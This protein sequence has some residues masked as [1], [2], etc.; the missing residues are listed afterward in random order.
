VPDAVLTAERQHLA[1]ARA[2]LA[3][4]RAHTAT[5]LDTQHAWGND[6]LT[7][8]ALAASLARRYEQLLDDGVTPLFFGR[9]DTETDEVFHVGR[10]HVSG[11][12]GEP[13]VLD[14]RAPVASS[15]YRASAADRQGL[16]LRRRFG[17]RD[18]A[19]TAY[20]DDRLSAGTGVSRL[21]LQEI[22]RP[23]SGPMRDIVA[24]VQ[25]EQDLL[26]RAPLEQTVCV[27]GAPGTGKTA[28]GLH[29]A[30][31]LL[32]AHRARLA[33]TGVLV[34]GPNRAFLSYVQEV[35]PALGE[36]QVTQATA[37]D[38]APRVPVRRTAGE[39]EAQV[40]GD[41][42]SAVV[43]ERALWLHAVRADE[44]LVLSL[45]SQRWRLW[46][47]DVH[48]LERAVRARGLSWTASRAALASALASALVRQLD[49]AGV[50]S[51]DTAVERLTRDRAVRSY[52]DRLWPPL[53]PARLVTAL[54]ADREL[55]ARAGDGVLTDAEQE[56]FASGTPKRWSQADLP[57]LDEAAHLLDRVPGYA[58]VVVDEAQDLS[59]MQLRAVGRRCVTGSATVLG[60]LAQAT[61][62]GAPGD[63]PEV[64]RHLG[65]PA[66]RLDVLTTG[67]R[68]PREVLDLANRLL[69]HI[70][71]GVAAASSLRSVPGSLQV[72]RTGDLI[73]DAARAV[74][75]RVAAG[76]VAVVAAEPRLLQRVGAA[77]TRH[78]V[79]ADLLQDGGSPGPVSLVPSALVKGLEFDGVVLLEPAAIAA[80]G[81]YGLRALYVALTRAVTSLVVLHSADLPAELSASPADGPASRPR[82]ADEQ[83]A[84]VPGLVQADDAPPSV[85]RRADA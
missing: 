27:Q 46:P 57:L 66:G 83:V 63:W 9:L 15:Y 51:S 64:L 67:Y 60:D 32:Y 8:R 16:V 53:T 10:R 41:A 24:T 54:L 84:H 29:R 44:P 76:S 68:V 75:D 81:P 39:A 50:S 77:L 79:A 22:E 37:D 36:V 52:V 40:K 61:T 45:G 34:V 26:V 70:A 4:M 28:V 30:A 82:P 80:S 1:R 35:L 55:L 11:A 42:R 31:Y 58:H 73:E 21:L 20:E 72:R 56:A 49:A 48:A 23:R 18:G 62:P 13:V 17:F 25:P 19:L 74:L 3:R 6:E 7:S 43:I 65:K 69:P 33:T 12:D 2:D 47:E 78:G 59:A 5:L 71:P 85:A 14:W 38:L